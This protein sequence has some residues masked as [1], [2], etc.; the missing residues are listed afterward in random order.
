[1]GKKHFINRTRISPILLKNRSANCLGWN[2]LQSIYFWKLLFFYEG[3]FKRNLEEPDEWNRGAYLSEALVHCGEC[4]T[5]RN[6]LGALK[7]NK[8]MA[9]TQGGPD[10]HSV[11]NITPDLETGI[12]NWSQKAIVEALK[13][14]ILPNGDFVGGAMSEVS[15][16]TANLTD[17]DLLAIAKYLSSLPA[18]KNKVTV[19]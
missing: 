10:G 3:P 16:N 12:G 18:V 13:F 15:D 2:S 14:G 5:P 19:K 8:S 4:H 7:R 1:M 11:P 17:F 6:F 9:G